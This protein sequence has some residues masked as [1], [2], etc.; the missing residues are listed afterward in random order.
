MH[1]S[2]AERR[3]CDDET[4]QKALLARGVRGFVR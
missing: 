4:Q 3:T 2:V 1:M